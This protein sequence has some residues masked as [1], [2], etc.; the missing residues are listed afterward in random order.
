MNGC[1]FV[2]LRQLNS[3]NMGKPH[4][5][6][7]KRRRRKQYIKRKKQLTNALIG[8]KKISTSKADAP[9]KEDTQAKADPPKKAP[10]KKAAKKTAKKAAAKKTAKKAAKKATKKVAKKAAK[11]S[12]ET[13]ED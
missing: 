11:K 8:A 3:N 9:V 7:T 10:A 2:I 1:W 5:T 12:T 4:R 6:A 13:K